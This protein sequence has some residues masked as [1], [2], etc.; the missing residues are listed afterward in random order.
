MITRNPVTPSP[1]TVHYT[2]TGTAINGNDYAAIPTFVTLPANVA[3]APITL[4]PKNNHLYKPAQTIIAALCPAATA[5]SIDQGC[6]KAN[7]TLTHNE[8][9]VAVASTQDASEPNGNPGLFTLTATRPAGTSPATS[10]S[11]PALA[12]KVPYTVAGTAKNGTDYTLSPASPVLVTI[13]LGATV[14]TTTITV[15]PKDHQT[16]D[17]ARTVTLTLGTG[18]A[19]GHDPNPSNKTATVNI[20]TTLSIPVPTISASLPSSVTRGTKVTVAWTIT[21]WTAMKL[22]LGPPAAAR[23]FRPGGPPVQTPITSCPV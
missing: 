10:L 5:Y 15:T 22:N 14:G 8:P 6:P 19:F 4:T 9:T 7:G 13:P 18:T 17:P 20:Q 21:N 16:V 3:S 11:L 23:S 1:L 2:M 12:I